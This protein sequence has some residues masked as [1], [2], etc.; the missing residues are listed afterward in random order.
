[1]EDDHLLTE[2]PQVYRKS[3]LSTLSHLDNPQRYYSVMLTQTSSLSDISSS[4]PHLKR[5]S[6]PCTIR[7]TKLRDNYNHEP[8]QPIRHPSNTDHLSL[9]NEDKNYIQ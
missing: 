2:R 4:K 6:K 8:L 1:M 5:P 7:S 9:Q 3:D